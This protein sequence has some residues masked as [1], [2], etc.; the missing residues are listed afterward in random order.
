MMLKTIESIRNGIVDVA[1]EC[2]DKNACRNILTERNSYVLEVQHS[3]GEDYGG[4]Q[5]SDETETTYE[6]ILPERILVKDGHFAG[7]SICV[8]YENYNG[9]GNTICDDAVILLDKTV[10][11]DTVRAKNGVYYS[12]DDHF[13][14]NYREYSLIPRKEDL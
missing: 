13:R 7:V 6:E 9:G 4:S 8:E 14:W 12:D 11:I 10:K 3:W 2:Y 5:C 1:L